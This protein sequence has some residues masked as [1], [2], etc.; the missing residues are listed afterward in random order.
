MSPD[1]QIVHHRQPGVAVLSAV[2]SLWNNNAVGRHAFFPWDAGRLAELLVPDGYPAGELLTAHPGG[3]EGECVAFAHVNRVREDGYP[4]AGVVENLL[5]DACHRRRGLGG[6]LLRRGVEMISAFRPRPPFV[7]ALGAWPFGYAFNCLA[8]GSER[9]GVFLNDPATYRLFRKFGFEPFRK[10]IV[11]RTPLGRVPPRGT[12]RGATF[13]TGR[14]G[15]NTWLD[16]VFRG[17]ELW[18]H[19]LVAGDG[20]VLSRAIFGFM[21][22]ESHREGRAVFSLFGVNTPFDLQGRGY[23]GV[24]ISN[25]M[26]YI[27][28]L[29]ADEVELHVY[30]DNT[31]ALRLYQGLGFRALG[32]TMAM[33]KALA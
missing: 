2:A 30:A 16:R 10:S 9:S 7:D 19:D 27:R 1:Y 33:H 26:A 29:G 25:M 23:A 11:M 32:E 15:Q 13:Y 28:G 4:H 18:D 24:N 22:G 12:P 8:D 6:E 14:R 20:R 3:A 17:R 31:P 21:E 5:V